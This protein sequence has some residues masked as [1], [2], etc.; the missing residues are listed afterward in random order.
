MIPGIWN[1]KLC[2]FVAD[3]THPNVLMSHLHDVHKIN[4]KDGGFQKYLDNNFDVVACSC[5]C[6]QQV[7]LHKREFAFSRF[8]PDCDGLNRS[9]SPGCIDFYLH[10]GMGVDE[11]VETFRLRQAVIAKGHSTEDLRDKLSKLNLGENNP[12]SVSSIMKRTGKSRREVH[13]ELSNKSSGS[14]NGFYGKS[15]ADDVLVANA[16]RIANSGN[17][18]VIKPEMIMWA[19]L[20]ALGIDFLFEESVDRYI[21]DFKVGDIIIEVYGDYW[22]K[23][24]I[25]MRWSDRGTRDNQRTQKLIGLGY[26]VEV[27]WESE[28]LKTPRESFERLKLIFGKAQ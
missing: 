8:A 1:C 22:H 2:S 7:R 6:G 10:R 20:H 11:A 25:K 5:G 14:N 16:N 13:A 24:D 28:L 12:A 23:P 18:N 15:H 9:R 27:F 21:A 17:K 3:G 26:L 19:F 4:R